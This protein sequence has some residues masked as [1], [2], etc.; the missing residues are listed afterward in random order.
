VVVA[1]QSPLCVV[2]GTVGPRIGEALASSGKRVGLVSGRLPVDERWSGCA[3]VDDPASAGS[4]P[5]HTFPELDG[6]SGTRQ[7]VASL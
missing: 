1:P 3:V 7:G 2:L 5:Y 4:Q 6:S